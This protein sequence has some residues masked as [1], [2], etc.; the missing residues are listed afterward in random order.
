[1]L[2]NIAIP[3]I[4]WLFLWIGEDLERESRQNLSVSKR[5]SPWILMI[6]VNMASG[7]YS[8]MGVMLGT[9]LI[10][11]CSLILMIRYKKLSIA[12]MGAATCIPN[13]IYLLMYLSM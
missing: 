6:L 8:S 1:M 5:L 4:L 10:G 2:A 3:L 7:I 11:A 9:I 12:F 13:V